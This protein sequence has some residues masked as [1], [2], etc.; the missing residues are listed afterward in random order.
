[1]NEHSRLVSLYG[2]A[3][4]AEFLDNVSFHNV[5]VFTLF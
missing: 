1:M 2:K 3:R 4:S 5:I